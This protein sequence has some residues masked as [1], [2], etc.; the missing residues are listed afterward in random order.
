MLSGSADQSTGF[1]VS[2]TLASRPNEKFSIEVFASHSDGIDG[3]GE[4]EVFLGK[5]DASS[6]AAGLARFSLTTSTDP[7]KDG[8]RSVYFTAT[9][10]R[11]SNGQTS[12]FSRPQLV[13]RP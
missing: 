8:T 3:R 5:V 1:L 2:G 12:E 7:L 10:T 4:G 9:A 13:R 6:D 11:S